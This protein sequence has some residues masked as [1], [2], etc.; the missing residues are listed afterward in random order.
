LDGKTRSS[1]VEDRTSCR[2]PR[3]VVLPE[4]MTKS[5]H[6]VTF[7]PTEECNPHFDKGIEIRYVLYGDCFQ[8]PNEDA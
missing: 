3:K 2:A 4:L 1:R 8:K 5:N 7:T 6:G